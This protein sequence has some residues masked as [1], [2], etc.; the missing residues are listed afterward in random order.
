MHNLLMTLTGFAVGG[1]V[2]LTGMGGGALMTP[3]LVLVFGIQ[4]GAAVSSDLVAALVMKPVGGAVHARRGT[5]HTGL[6]RWLCLGSVPAAFVGALALRGLGHGDELQH[7]IGLVIGGALLLASTGMIVKTVMTRRRSARP[8]TDVR[9]VPVKPIPTLLIGIGGGL[10]VGLTSVG[11]GSL[12]LVTLLAVYPQL[13]AGELVGTDLVQAIPLVAAATLGHVLFGQV[14]FALAGFLIL[15]AVPGVYVGAR[16][17]AVAPDRVIRPALI[18]VL[19]LS[20]LKLLGL[21]TLGVG[22][23]ALV[24]AA[25]IGGWL[26]TVSRLTR[27]TTATPTT[28]TPTD[29]PATTTPSGVSPPAA[30]GGMQAGNRHAAARH[31]GALGS[32]TFATD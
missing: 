7:R 23:V 1:I 20:G 27:P 15:G 18:Y 29:I 4:P 31:D 16:L 21:S 19:T 26:L 28:D 14:Q 12:M 13:T 32:T 30:D 6:V 22:I 5:V 2:G 9:A 17:S 3:L 10:I 24:L 25:L 11:S 8:H